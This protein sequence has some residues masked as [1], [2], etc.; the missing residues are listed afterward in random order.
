MTCLGLKYI[1]LTCISSQLFVNTVCEALCI[2]QLEM[3]DKIRDV[4]IWCCNKAM[5]M[6]TVTNNLAKPLKRLPLLFLLHCRDSKGPKNATSLSCSADRLQENQI[7]PVATS[8]VCNVS[9]LSGVNNAYILHNQF[10][11]ATLTPNWTQWAHSG[12]TDKHLNETLNDSD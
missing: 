9:I 11:F 2:V 4:P 8:E 1:N 12:D 3:R 7:S 10:L 6:K 5:P